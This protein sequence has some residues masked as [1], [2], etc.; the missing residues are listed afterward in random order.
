MMEKKSV[1]GTLFF[2]ILLQ[3]E[4]RVGGTLSDFHRTEGE[5]ECSP[6]FLPIRKVGKKSGG[7]T[8][9]PIC[10]VGKN[11][12]GYTFEETIDCGCFAIAWAVHLA[13]GDKPETIILDQTQVLSHLEACLLTHQFIP[14]SHTIKKTQRTRSQTLSV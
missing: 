4:K 8:V 10:K 5:K 7:Y 3:W 2:S 13:Y 12:G 14:F 9:F 1:G 11:S 6:L